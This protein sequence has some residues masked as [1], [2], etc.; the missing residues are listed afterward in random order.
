MVRIYLKV[1][2]KVPIVPPS[3][4]N[5][6]QTR[7]NNLAEGEAKIDFHFYKNVERFPEYLLKFGFI[8]LFHGF[9]CS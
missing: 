1:R 4:E 8:F 3:A 6:E 5:E 7:P 9:V 2:L